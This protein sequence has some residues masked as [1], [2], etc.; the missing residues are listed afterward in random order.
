MIKFISTPN[1]E[2]R[3]I[4]PDVPDITVEMSTED[5]LSLDNLGDMFCDFARAIG[6]SDEVVERFSS[7][8]DRCEGCELI[9]MRAKLDAGFTGQANLEGGIVW[10]PSP[11]GTDPTA[12]EDD[13]ITGEPV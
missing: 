2:R 9:E 1:K 12:A 7:F 6:F 10:T 13:E 3:F 4:S 8:Y 11:D 5:V